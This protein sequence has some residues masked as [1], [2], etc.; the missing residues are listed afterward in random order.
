M[1]TLLMSCPVAMSRVTRTGKR[2]IFQTC[3]QRAQ[4]SMR[5]RT[6]QAQGLQDVL[7]VGCRAKVYKAR[8]AS[9]QAGCQAPIT[10]STVP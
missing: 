1:R 2:T 10:C 3:L 6:E 7:L 5:P 9:C 8:S 4:S